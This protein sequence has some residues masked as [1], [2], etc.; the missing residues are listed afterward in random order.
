MI[1]YYYPLTL[2]ESLFI[3]G[4]SIILVILKNSAGN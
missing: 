1:Y 2:K 3:L 4:I